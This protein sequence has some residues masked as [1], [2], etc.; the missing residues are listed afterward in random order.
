MY[1]LFF[2]QNEEIYD[3][4]LKKIII[5]LYD[6]KFILDKYQIKTKDPWA[7]YYNNIKLLENKETKENYNENIKIYN[8]KYALKENYKR[9][10]ENRIS[11]IKSNLN[12]KK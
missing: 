2:K 7:L 8:F 11:E 10:I 4:I 3:E 9:I 6:N 5:L 1:K 12:I